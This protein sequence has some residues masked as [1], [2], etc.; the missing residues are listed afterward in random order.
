M[1]A[2][3]NPAA[4]V[5]LDNSDPSEGTPKCITGFHR[6]AMTYSTCTREDILRSDVQVSTEKMALIQG[7]VIARESG[8]S[9]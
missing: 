5:S 1:M 6:A 4:S 3:P 8:T 9:L 7:F 2:E